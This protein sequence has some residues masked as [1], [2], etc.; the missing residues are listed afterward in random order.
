MLVDGGAACPLADVPAMH[1]YMRNHSSLAK[2][3]SSHFHYKGPLSKP[4][5]NLKVKPL[6]DAPKPTF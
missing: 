6:Y 4:V 3:T 2:Q 5:K 1:M